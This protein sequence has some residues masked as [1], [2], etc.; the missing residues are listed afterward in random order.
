M[1]EKVYSKEEVVE[2]INDLLQRPD[3]LND[4]MYNGDTDWDASS[5]F[6][7]IISD[8]FYTEQK[9]QKIQ[10]KYRNLDMVVMKGGV[11]INRI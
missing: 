6:N 4:M 11:E 5:I 7:L 10:E 2:I 9:I 8:M 3:L 1:E